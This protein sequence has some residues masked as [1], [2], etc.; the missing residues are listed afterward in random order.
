VRRD[1]EIELTVTADGGIREPRVVAGG[2]N[3]RLAGQALRAVGTAR[4]RP[5][6]VDGQPVATQDV[7]FVQPFYVS[8][9]DEQTSPPDAGP[10]E[11]APAV[12]PATPPAQGPG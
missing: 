9:K 7:R 10:D 3:E 4:Y 5:R 1:V 2:D 12:A 8:N 6:L 11:K